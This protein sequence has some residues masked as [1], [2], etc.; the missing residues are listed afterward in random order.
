MAPP[1]Q[2]VKPEVSGQ[3]PR[4]HLGAG[5]PCRSLTRRSWDASTHTRGALTSGSLSAV[6]P[7]GPGQHT[8]T[9][10][11]TRGR[12]GS[13]PAAAVPPARP[14]LRGDH[15]LLV[16]GRWPPAAEGTAPAPL[17]E[18]NRALVP[19]PGP[20]PGHK[21]FLRMLLC[22]AP[23]LPLHSHPHTQ[24]HVPTWTCGRG[25]GQAAGVEPTTTRW[26]VGAAC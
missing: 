17:S 10:C 7:R 16:R 13:P 9:L 24:N 15:C 22:G 18:K 6:P 1:P 14:T 4:S 25:K 12:R 11:V 2:T 20:R 5:S 3:K 21:P 19:F 8:M 23:M 26:P